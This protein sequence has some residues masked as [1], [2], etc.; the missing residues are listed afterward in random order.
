MYHCYQPVPLPCYRQD[1]CNGTSSFSWFGL[2]TVINVGICELLMPAVK[3]LCGTTILVKHG[4]I[5]LSILV[6]PWLNTRRGVSLCIWEFHVLEGFLLVMS[7]LYRA[8]DIIYILPHRN[9]SCWGWWLLSLG[10]QDT[11]WD[12]YW[13]GVVICLDLRWLTVAFFLLY[14]VCESQNSLHFLREWRYVY[15]FNLLSL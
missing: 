14:L 13:M 5:L 12:K 4:K 6:R 8:F 2:A 7:G 11:L 15:I 9:L 3:Q 10:I 1:G